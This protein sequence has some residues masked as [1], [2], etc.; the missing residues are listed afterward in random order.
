MHN[1]TEI[2][3]FIEARQRFRE[4]QEKVQNLAESIS[5]FVNSADSEDIKLLAEAMNCDHRTLVQS[6]FG[7]FL[8]FAKVLSENYKNNN[9]D[10]RNKYACKM[11]TEIMKLTNGMSTCPF[12]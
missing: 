7:L 6:K 1:D 4:K 2:K 5:N 8:E 3:N 10:I 11:S 9:F 12:I